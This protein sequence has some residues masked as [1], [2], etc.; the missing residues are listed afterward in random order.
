MNITTNGTHSEIRF[1]G[2]LDAVQWLQ[3]Q[4]GR[5]TGRKV[6]DKGGSYRWDATGYAYNNK[7]P[8]TM[9]SDWPEQQEL[10]ASGWH[11]GTTEISAN[12]DNIKHT[13]Q[14]EFSGY[15]FDVT[16]QFFDV[17]LV[18]SGEPE[19][20]LQEEAQPI[21]KTV[22]ICINLSASEAISADSLSIRGAAVLAL[23]DSLQQIG[24]IV[25][26]TAVIGARHEKSGGR[27]VTANAW[28]DLGTTPLD[29]DAAALIMAHA[30]F[31]GS[32]VLR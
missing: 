6:R 25:E 7:R 23:A 1:R 13:L 15:R 12:L 31:S 4:D 5:G 17:G 22:S 32:Q 19:C 29:I 11:S 24:W 2:P 28:F 3:A 9:H 8:F 14:D 20:W 16:G 10:A 30:G 18:V 21:R 26:L 27:D